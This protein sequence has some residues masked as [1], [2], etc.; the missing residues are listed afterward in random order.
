MVFLEDD[1][2][3]ES[4]HAEYHLFFYSD[5]CYILSYLCIYL[6]DDDDDMITC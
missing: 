3:F 1:Q 4:K 6:S 5:S 2:K